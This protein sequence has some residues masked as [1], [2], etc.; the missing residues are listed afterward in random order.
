MNTPAPVNVKQGEAVPVRSP[1][2][3]FG[4]LQRE[5][6]RLFDDFAPGFVVP[7]GRSFADVKCRMDLA[8][9]KDGLELS[10]E[11]PGLEEK[12]VE[13]S[14][15]DGVLTVSGEKKF[16]TEHKDKTYRFVERGYGSFS[17]DVTLPDGVKADDI[18][19]TMS[20]GVLRIAIPTPAKSQARKIEVKP[21][22]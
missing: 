19:A 16:E 15:A 3:M 13:V 5:I 12:D 1:F 14:V 21:A 22:A 20:K 11:L 17:R 7:P 18:K 8:E 10:V 2:G 6:D 9:T 4:S